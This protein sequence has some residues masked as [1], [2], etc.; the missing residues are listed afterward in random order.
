MFNELI[1]VIKNDI[2]NYKEILEKK[3]EKTIYI[4]ISITDRNILLYEKNNNAI[5]NCKY[6]ILKQNKDKILIVEKNPKFYFLNEKK[7][8]K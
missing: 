2:S 5:I 4:P 3:F 7:E 8:K 1:E 6:K